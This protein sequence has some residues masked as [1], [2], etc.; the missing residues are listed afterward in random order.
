MSIFGTSYPKISGSLGE[1]FLPHSNM[2]T[3]YIA[4]EVIE[5]RSIITGHISYLKKYSRSKF[6]LTYMLCDETGSFGPNDKYNEL[7]SYKDKLFKFYPH[8]DADSIKDYLGSEA[9]FFITRFEPYYLSQ[10]STYDAINIEMISTKPTQAQPIY[11]ETITGY[12]YGYGYLYGTQ[13]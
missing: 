4:P 2:N 12:G 3:N 13:L 7:Y 10:D 6:S 1:V 5:H 8:S 9:D 11:V